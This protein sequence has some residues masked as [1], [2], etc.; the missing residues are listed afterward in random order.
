MA[1]GLNLFRLFQNSGK[2]KATIAVAPQ[3]SA[4]LDLVEKELKD[5][6]LTI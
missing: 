4:E 2:I 6:S 3:S 5:N 1:I